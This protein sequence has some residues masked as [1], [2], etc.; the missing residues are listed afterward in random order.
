MTSHLE[1]LLP[2]DGVVLYFGVVLSAEESDHYFDC[3]WKEVAWQN[4]EA[5]IFG[6]HFVTKR[7]VAWNGDSEYDYTYSKVT[8]RAKIW[9]P[10]LL[11]L[12][13][14]AESYTGST[15]NSCLCN[16]YHEGDEGMAWHSDDEKK[17]EKDSSIASLTFGA[18]RKFAFKHKVDKE[19]VSLQLSHGSLL[20]MK[21]TTQTYWWHRLPTT[22]LI[23]GPRINLT[24]RKIIL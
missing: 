11:G 24:F 2:K 18:T 6:K 8:K 7:K 23:T 12:K 19:V 22:K 21:G 16:L 17:I 20:E 10:T 1:N 14:L 15:Y 9:T 3:L 5:R 13:L 4:D